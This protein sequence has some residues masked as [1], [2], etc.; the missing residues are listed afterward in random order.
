MMEAEPP[1]PIE[2]AVE[3]NRP[4][5]GTSSAPDP[6]LP[7]PAPPSPPPSV[8]PPLRRRGEGK[9]LA[10]VAAGLADHL[11]VDV[12]VVRLVI[13][14]LTIL[15]E[16][17][18]LLA[19]LVA[20]ILI[21]ADD[22]D[23]AGTRSDR[24]PVDRPPR[25]ALFWVG[26]GLLVLGGMWLL[27]GPFSAP[28][29]LPGGRDL[30]WPLVLVGFGLALWRAGDRSETSRVRPLDV[31]STEQP[32]WEPQPAPQRTRSLLTR[33]TLGLALLTTGV[34]WLLRE[35]GVYALT[36]ARILAAALLVIGAGLLVGS[37]AGRGHWLILAG[38]LLLPV[39]ILASLLHPYGMD[40]LPVSAVRQGAGEVLATPDDLDELRAGYQLGVGSIVLDLTGVDVDRPARVQLQV[41]AGEVQVRLPDDVTA[42]VTSRVGMGEIGLEGRLTTGAGLQRSAS[43]ERGEG[44]ALLQIDIQVGLGEISVDP[45]VTE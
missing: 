35:T 25:D 26:V 41:G 30:L 11:A 19:Y 1:D 13:V 44:S 43:V 42:E 28:F 34:L 24:A 2:R 14:V 16:G 5:P 17:V 36:P 39:V 9:M 38:G 22:R 27:G 6:E 29:L 18:G 21:P 8:R 7:P 20:A 12:T 37:V 32:R 3:P 33:A 40:D 23:A 10:G 31:P 45:H 15:T 4:S